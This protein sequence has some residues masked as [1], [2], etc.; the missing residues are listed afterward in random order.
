MRLNRNYDGTP[1]AEIGG[2]KDEDYSCYHHWTTGETTYGLGSL[3]VCKQIKSGI[4]WMEVYIIRRRSSINDVYLLDENEIKEWED[5]PAGL[6]WNTREKIEMMYNVK[7]AVREEESKKS[8]KKRKASPKATKK[9][10]SGE[11]VISIFTGK[12]V[13]KRPKSIPKPSPR[14]PND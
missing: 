14:D 6:L 9:A 1:I 7:R 10:P 13:T 4:W 11:S 5:E 2:I 8:Q 12:P 3:R